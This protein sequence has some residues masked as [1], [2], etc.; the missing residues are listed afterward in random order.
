MKLID[1][2]HEEINLYAVLVMFFYMNLKILLFT[3]YNCI[4][5]KE[6]GLDKPGQRSTAYR[7][8]FG[9]LFFLG[10]FLFMMR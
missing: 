6:G 7:A 8:N 5:V 10:I 2:C 4:L 9:H 3:C 1:F